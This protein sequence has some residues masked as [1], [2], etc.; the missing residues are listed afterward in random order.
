MK[1]GRLV[2]RDQRA[3]TSPQPTGNPLAAVFAYSPSL[4]ILCR[5][6]LELLREIILLLGSKNGSFK[7]CHR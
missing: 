2:S 5:H 7:V 1:R 6:R 3:V 4:N